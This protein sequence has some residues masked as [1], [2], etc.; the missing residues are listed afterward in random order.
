VFAGATLPFP[1]TAAERAARGD[2]RPSI[3]ERYASLD[4]YLARVRDAARALVTDGYLLEEDVETSLAFGRR[5]WE[6]WAT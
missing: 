2:P 1:K 4:Q 5:L 6:A 3:A